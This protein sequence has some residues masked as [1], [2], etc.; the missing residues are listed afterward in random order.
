MAPEEYGGGIWGWLR[1]ETNR[2][3]IA[4]FGSGLVIV[5]SGLWVVYQKYD[6]VA[7]KVSPP[8]PTSSVTISGDGVVAGRDVNQGTVV[9]NPVPGAELGE[10]APTSSTVVIGGDGVVGG[11]DVNTGTL[12]FGDR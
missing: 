9:G 6:P 10:Q 11:R 2:K 5:T 8:V 3:V 1:D 4:W 12:V 7:K